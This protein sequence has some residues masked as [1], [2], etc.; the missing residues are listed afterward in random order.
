MNLPYYSL[1]I[2]YAWIRE[3]LKFLEYYQDELVAQFDLTETQQKMYFH[4]IQCKGSP[5]SILIKNQFF[6]QV[7]FITHDEDTSVSI[8]EKFAKLRLEIRA[9]I[10]K[11][12][13][14]AITFDELFTTKH[15]G[16]A[17][18]AHNSMLFS[19][20]CYTVPRPSNWKWR[21]TT[22]ELV[23]C[24]RLIAANQ[25]NSPAQHRSSTV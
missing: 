12:N 21:N 20:D 4:L 17:M 3:H 25:K 1:Y 5:S 7:H 2:V 10:G 14:K 9:L 18:F 16:V 8:E 6:S 13:V 23:W 15:I 11:T 22:L 24:L 19:E